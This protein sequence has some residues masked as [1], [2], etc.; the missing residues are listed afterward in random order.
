MIMKVIKLDEA[1]YRSALQGL[2]LNKKK[3]LVA[4]NTLAPKLAKMDGLLISVV[5]ISQNPKEL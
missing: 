4:M 2:A 3:D 5:I 1:G